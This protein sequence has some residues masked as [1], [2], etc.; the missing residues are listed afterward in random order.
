MTQ[1]HTQQIASCVVNAVGSS[2]LSVIVTEV[3]KWPMLRPQGEVLWMVDVM[4]LR[5]PILCLLF[6]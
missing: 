2:S 6:W 3:R 5:H 1:H 4:T